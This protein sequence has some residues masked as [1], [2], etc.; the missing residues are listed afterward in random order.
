MRRPEA[1]RRGENVAASVREFRAQTP[2][3][4]QQNRA[5]HVLDS[6][7]SNSPVHLREKGRK[8]SLMLTNSTFSKPAGKTHL[9]IHDLEQR[10]TMASRLGVSEDRLR[11]AVRI[12]GTRISTLAS[13]F[14]R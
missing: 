11:K 7:S 8:V 12:V 13:Y 14:E 10:S 5:A 2:E 6:T 3:G 9:D 1:P 4:A